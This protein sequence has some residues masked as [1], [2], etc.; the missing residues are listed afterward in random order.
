M[1]HEHVVD[2]MF[3]NISSDCLVNLTPTA[4]EQVCKFIEEGWELYYGEDEE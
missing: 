2:E 1:V 4:R 3:G